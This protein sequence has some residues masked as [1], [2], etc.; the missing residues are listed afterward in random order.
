MLTSTGHLKV[1][2]FGTATVVNPSLVKPTLLEK[3]REIKG[4][5]GE[6]GEGQLPENG[7][8]A[9]FVGTAEYVSPE[10]LDDEICSYP[11]DLWALG[12]ICY[13]M[14]VGKTPFS[15]STDFNI[16][17][18]VKS[19]TY[20]LPAEV[21][22]EAADFVRKL[23]IR[24]PNSRLGVENNSVNYKIIKQHPLFKGVNFDRLYESQAP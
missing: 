6:D 21:P 22:L 12:V 3:F 14:F 20:N 24:D 9:T 2:D 4:F 23:L 5:K 18:N 17:N 13:K 19:V 8:R 1:I 11:A 10:L 16:F 15:G 7:H